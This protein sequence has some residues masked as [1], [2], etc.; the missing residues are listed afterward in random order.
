MVMNDHGPLLVNDCGPMTT[1]DCGPM[2][3]NYCQPMPANGYGLVFMGHYWTIAHLDGGPKSA[4]AIGPKKYDTVPTMH[5]KRR[6]VWVI[7]K[8]DF[9]FSFRK[10]NLLLFCENGGILPDIYFNGELLQ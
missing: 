1:N 7:I 3:A 5:Q 2:P 10:S 9:A 6:A 4:T 8:I